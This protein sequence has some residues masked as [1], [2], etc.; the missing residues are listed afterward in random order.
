M[1]AVVVPPAAVRI[2]HFFLSQSAV[3]MLRP[4]YKKIA[5]PLTHTLTRML[6]RG[7]FGRAKE[8]DTPTK[9]LVSVLEV[10]H[11]AALEKVVLSTAS[12]SNKTFLQD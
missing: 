9:K 12:L 8:N 10:V 5:T 2:K 1:R 4:V 6:L 11:D 3:G 7:A